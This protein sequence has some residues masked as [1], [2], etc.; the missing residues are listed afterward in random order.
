METN[1]VGPTPEIVGYNSGHFDTNSNTGDWWR[2][3]GV[4]G[5]RIFISPTQIEPSDELP[6]WDKDGVTDANSF[7]A[8]KAFPVRSDPLNTNYF[9]WNYV[10]N[11][12]Y[13]THSFTG[14]DSIIVNYACSQWRQDGIQIL[15]S[16]HRHRSPY[17]QT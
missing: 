1:V 10:T 16:M 4:T 15:S 13:A 14:S 9:N 17:S 3:S 11:R 2:Y 8:R 12:A 7:A 5:A 6:P